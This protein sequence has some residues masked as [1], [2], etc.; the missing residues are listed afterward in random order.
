MLLFDKKAAHQKHGKEKNG[1]NKGSRQT[2]YQLRIS[3]EDQSRTMPSHILHR[4][5]LQVGHVAQDGEYQH[6]SGQTCA[7][8]DNAGD[9]SIPKIEVKRGEI[10]LDLIRLLQ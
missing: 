9:E 4:A 6:A 2:Q 3:Q 5:I 1:P 8:V 10:R 7:S